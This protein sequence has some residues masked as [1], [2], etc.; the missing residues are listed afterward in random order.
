MVTAVRFCIRLLD[1]TGPELLPRSLG[2]GDLRRVRRLGRRASAALGGLLA[3][4]PVREGVVDSVGAP[5]AI[6]KEPHAVQAAL[7][8][9]LIDEQVAYELRLSRNHRQRCEEPAVAHAPLP[10]VVC[11]KA[12]STDHNV[13]RFGPQPPPDEPPIALRVRCVATPQEE[14]ASLLA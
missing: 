6:D 2:V 1:Q 7:G 9:H 11:A 14:A 8:R 4:W 5:R 12:V 10:H 13:T 3:G